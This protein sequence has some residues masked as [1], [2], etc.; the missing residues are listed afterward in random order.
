[1]SIIYI[2]ITI[3]ISTIV[4]TLIIIWIKI[5]IIVIDVVIL[6]NGKWKIDFMCAA[7]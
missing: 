7:V 4:G 3:A 5:G 6:V 2:S 1:M